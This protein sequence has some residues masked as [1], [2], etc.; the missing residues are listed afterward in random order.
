MSAVT[1]RTSRMLVPTQTS[2]ALP[3]EFPQP[4][5]GGGTKRKRKL[6]PKAGMNK[7]MGANPIKGTGPRPKGRV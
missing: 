1:N 4:A 7:G 5:L 2:S 6:Q 3:A